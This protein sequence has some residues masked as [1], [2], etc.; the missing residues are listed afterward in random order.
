MAEGEGNQAVWG[1]L[2]AKISGACRH[3]SALL[4]VRLYNR[5]L[6]LQSTRKLHDPCHIMLS[7]T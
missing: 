7:Q 2:Y 4:W 6:R 5:R 3:K 1:V